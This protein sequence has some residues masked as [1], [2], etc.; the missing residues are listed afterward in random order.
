MHFFAF[1]FLSFDLSVRSELDAL[2]SRQLFR[3][4]KK[5]VV[6]APVSDPGRSSVESNT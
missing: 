2:V 6:G 1:S 5:N 3:S 4:W